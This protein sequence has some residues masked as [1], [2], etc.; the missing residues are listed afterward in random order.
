MIIRVKTTRI[1]FSEK[2]WGLGRFASLPK[3]ALTFCFFELRLGQFYGTNLALL[4]GGK[5][6]PARHTGRHS[7]TDET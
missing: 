6:Q 1:K 7:S 2:S 5:L 4:K 3:F